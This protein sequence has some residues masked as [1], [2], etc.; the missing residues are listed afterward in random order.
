VRVAEQAYQG[1]DP[2][3]RRVDLVLRPARP[4]LDLYLT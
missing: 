3:E 2:V 1:G 4:D